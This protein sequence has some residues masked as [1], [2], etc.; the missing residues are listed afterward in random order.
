MKLGEVIPRER[1]FIYTRPFTKE[2]LL[3]ELA[4]ATPYRRGVKKEV[5]KLIVEREKVS[6]TG[7]GDGVAIPHTKANIPDPIYCSLAIVQP[8]MDFSSIDSHP[9]NL[10]FFLVSGR[11]ATS[12]Q[13]QILSQISQIIRNSQFR[14]NLLSCSTPEEAHQ[15]IFEEEREFAP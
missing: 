2:K 3:Q 4:F 9:V 14:E 15:M 5:H 1:I 12:Q 13:I 10:V 7:V 8:P 11:E 6:S